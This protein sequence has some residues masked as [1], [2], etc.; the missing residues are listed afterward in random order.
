MEEL[1]RATGHGV[2]MAAWECQAKRQVR[3]EDFPPSW[4]AGEIT[5]RSHDSRCYGR[6]FLMR[7]DEPTRMQLQDLS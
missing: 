7:L 2:S 1:E 6:R 5:P 4:Q 3:L